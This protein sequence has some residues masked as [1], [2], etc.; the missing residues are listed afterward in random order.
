MCVFLVFTQEFAAPLS[1]KMTCRSHDLTHFSMSSV[2][3][4]DNAACA[5]LMMICDK[6][7]TG[8]GIRT[9]WTGII[10]GTRIITWRGIITGTGIYW[11][12]QN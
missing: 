3:A 4:K 12:G 11:V 1:V 8:A 7:R 2:L 10:T 5:H 6:D 9:A